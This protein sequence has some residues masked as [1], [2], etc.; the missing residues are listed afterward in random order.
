M[1]VGSELGMSVGFI[2]TASLASAAEPQPSSLTL[3][4]EP[5]SV[6]RDEVLPACLASR[7]EALP[8]HALGSRLRLVAGAL[9]GPHVRTHVTR[10][11]LRLSVNRTPSNVIARVHHEACSFPRSV[12]R[13]Q[14]GRNAVYSCQRA[15]P[16]RG[17]A[18]V[19]GI[20]A[21]ARYFFWVSSA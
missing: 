16:N 13:T 9:L 7:Y 20:R 21:A 11:S 14:K 19:P 4:V 5:L 3:R 2:A 1:L 12:E 10:Q 17:D 8:R 6:S 18:P 15:Q